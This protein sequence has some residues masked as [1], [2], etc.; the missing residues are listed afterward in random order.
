MKQQTREKSVL[1]QQQM[2]E[3]RGENIDWHLKYLELQLQ[4]NRNI[5]AERNQ[6]N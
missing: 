4:G 1:P 6:T 5:R 2:K 3:Q